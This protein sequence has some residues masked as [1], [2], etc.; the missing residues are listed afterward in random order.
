[1]TDK[2]YADL[3]LGIAFVY[4]MVAIVTF[5]HLMNNPRYCA[6]DPVPDVCRG[7]SAF[8]MV[9]AWPLYWSLELQRPAVH[10]KPVVK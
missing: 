9:P 8:F 2:D 7:A 10:G 6:D 5:G 1:M 3:F 4:L